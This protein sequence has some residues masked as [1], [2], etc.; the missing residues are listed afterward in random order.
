MFYPRKSNA[1]NIPNNATNLNMD[2][3]LKLQIISVKHYIQSLITSHFSYMHNEKGYA[4][5]QTAH[6]AKV[7]KIQPMD[8]IRPANWYL[9]HQPLPGAWRGRAEPHATPLCPSQGQARSYRTQTPPPPHIHPSHPAQLPAG[10]VP[11][12]HYGCQQSGLHGM[13]HDAACWVASLL[14][15]CDELLLPQL[16]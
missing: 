13:G 6:R 4:C 7:G 12:W 9:T 10:I 15:C 3:H 16:H 14:T 1:L 11:S 8:H 5:M 2:I